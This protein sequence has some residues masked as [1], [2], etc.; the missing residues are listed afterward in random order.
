MKTTLKI[1]VILGVSFMLLWLYIANCLY[2]TDHEWVYSQDYFAS[3]GQRILD[4]LWTIFTM[5]GWVA[6]IAVTVLMFMF[7]FPSL[8]K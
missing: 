5:F 1:I 8:R 6:W 2:W 4:G 3:S 7:I